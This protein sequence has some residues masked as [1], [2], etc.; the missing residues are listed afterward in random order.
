MM[1]DVLTG[2]AVAGASGTSRVASVD[3]IGTRT[4]DRVGME[5]QNSGSGVVALHPSGTRNHE[6]V[7][8]LK[9][10]LDG[11]RIGDQKNVNQ[12]TNSI[13]TVNG[14]LM[15]DT[16][17][18]QKMV[19]DP[20]KTKKSGSK[21]SSASVAMGGGP[22]AAAAAA[23]A[24]NAEKQKH[25][26]QLQHHHQNGLPPP[27]AYNRKRS[28]PQ[29]PLPESASA[30]GH[31]GEEKK[32]I[33]LK[34]DPDAKRI[35]LGQQARDSDVITEVKKEGVGDIDSSYNSTGLLSPLNTVKG[36]VKQEP[37]DEPNM[38]GSTI[39]SSVAATGD[40]ALGDLDKILNEENG[41]SIMNSDLLSDLIELNDLP[42]GFM[43]NIDM[44][45]YENG[46]LDLGSA[47]GN[48]LQHETGG[49][50]SAAAAAEANKIIYRQQDVAAGDAARTDNQG[51]GG[52]KRTG[53]TTEKF[54]MATN[55]QQ[56]VPLQVSHHRPG[57]AAAA[58]ASG[59]HS[60]PVGLPILAG[61]NRRPPPNLFESNSC[62]DLSMVNQMSGGGPNGPPG[63]RRMPN[64][65]TSP[66]PVAAAAAAAA[67]AGRT[68]PSSHS[69]NMGMG[70]RSSPSN[71]VPGSTMLSSVTSAP[72]PQIG[73]QHPQLLRTGA[74]PLAA[75]GSPNYHGAAP[76]QVRVK[77]AQSRYRM[78]TPS[79]NLIHPHQIQ[80][81]RHPQHSGQ[82]MV[83]NAMVLRPHTQVS[84]TFALD[85][86]KSNMARQRADKSGL[87]CSSFAVTLV[88]VLTVTCMAAKL[89]VL[90]SF[91]WSRYS[92][93]TGNLRKWILLGGTCFL[94]YHIKLVMY[95]SRKLQFKYCMVSTNSQ[96]L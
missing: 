18:L 88:V 26:L 1:S 30:G 16:I 33:V 53:P 79:S 90:L 24:S 50:E 40:D 12:Y 15:N 41:E 81:H 20:S 55:L 93:L 46:L 91:F 6:S 89:F 71:S 82:N 65:P 77:A 27:P 63:L 76:D 17:R 51:G 11:Y 5:M 67:A 8:R 86:I 47:I 64:L 70:P 57:A 25:N 73:V 34:D 60:S 75:P 48:E 52:D 49:A 45:D 62:S 43:D 13:N 35:N 56:H 39:H 84:R 58:A 44:N 87:I 66:L 2:S 59:V 19:S 78:G 38:N 69:S 31:S 4:A 96:L 14:Q 36:E 42:N 68:T 83:S 85:S 61:A 9:R 23:A 3:D 37:K 95:H 72:H 21:K 10:R 74:T 7:N 80:S 32:F 92:I 94:S 28:L 29:L 22:A 54:K